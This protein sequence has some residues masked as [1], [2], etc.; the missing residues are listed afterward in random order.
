M[1]VISLLKL[2]IPLLMLI[3]LFLSLFMSSFFFPQNVWR[4]NIFF[5]RFIFESAASLLLHEWELLFV[6]VPRPLIMVVSLVA[7]HRL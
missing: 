2:L 4:L 5:L 3:L 6:A 1:L 7:E